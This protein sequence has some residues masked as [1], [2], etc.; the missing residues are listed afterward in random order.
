[1]QFGEPIAAQFRAWTHV[2]WVCASTM[3]QV[4]VLQHGVCTC[5]APCESTSRRGT[6][7]QIW[8]AVGTPVPQQQGV[9]G[10]SYERQVELEGCCLSCQYGQHEYSWL[11]YTA[12]AEHQQSR[13]HSGSAAAA[14]ASAVGQW[15][16]VAVRVSCPMGQCVC[17]APGQVGTQCCQGPLYA[18][19]VA[20]V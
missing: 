1:M 6:L 15:W 9:A 2:W 18:G 11:L 14:E 16:G 8:G 10:A 3:Q 4:Q 19:S 12:T 13:R 20:R 7:P 17:L 5:R